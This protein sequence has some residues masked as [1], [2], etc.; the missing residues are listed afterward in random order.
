MKRAFTILAAAAI[1]CGAAE[2]LA[3]ASKTARWTGGGDR[4][5]V[6]DPANWAVT[7]SLGVAVENAVPDGE[8]AVVIEGDTDFNC[9]LG[10]T[11]AYESI[12]I[13]DATLTADCDWRG[14]AL[15]ASPDYIDAPNGAYLDTGFKPNQNTRVVMDVTV[16]GTGYQGVQYWFGCWN[17]AYNNG[18]FA[19]CNDPT[20][21]YSGYGN[22]GGASTPQ[23]ASGRH[24]I[25]FDKGVVKVD[26]VAHTTRTSSDFQVNYNLY[27]FTQNRA[28]TT[29][30]NASLQTVRFHSCQI[31]DDGTLVRDYVPTNNGTAF[32]IYDKVNETFLTSSNSSVPF[33][34]V[35]TSVEIGGTVDLAGHTLTLADAAGSGTVTDLSE[36]TGYI[37]VP[38][39][40]YLDTGFKPNQDTRVVMDVTVLGTKAAYWFGCWNVAFNNGAFAVGNDSGNV[41]SGYG[42]NGGGNG[43]KVSTGR[44]TIDFD[45][46]VVKVD[47]T[48]H[49]TRTAND[50]QVNYNLYLF[51]QNR[52]GTALVNNDYLETIR[53]HS[54]RIYDDG[55]LVRDYVPAYTGAEYG[56]FDKV[57]G[58]F[59]SLGGSA[60]DDISGSV[61]T[62]E[63]HIDVCD[64]RS[65]DNTTLSLS[66]LLKL[67]KEGSG[68]FTATKT[69]QTYVGGTAVSGGWLECAGAATS[70]GLAESLVTVADGAGFEWTGPLSATSSPYSFDIVGT[71]PGG[72]G[73]LVFSNTAGPWQSY[74]L[75]DLS[76]SGDALIVD[77]HTA[78]QGIFAGFVAGDS[79][80]LSLN[81]HT[82]TID[83]GGLFNFCHLTAANA[84]TIKFM[85]TKTDTGNYRHA[86]FWNGPIDLSLVTFDMGTGCRLNID[87]SSG[88]VTF[89]TFIDRGLTEGNGNR[90]LYVRDAFKPLTESLHKSIILGDST[91]LTPVLDLS[92]LDGTFALPASTYTLSAASEATVCV[93]VGERKLKNSEPLVSWTKPPSSMSFRWADGITGK[94]TLTVKDDG[95][96]AIQKG[97][98][99]I[100][101]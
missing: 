80:T 75:K 9:P 79:H 93:D 5:N 90:G 60:T 73:A 25:D 56:I 1:I 43:P 33:T 86:S 16:L 95:L 7:N 63:L 35:T 42:N 20:S 71:G 37:D 82:L 96:Y 53:F 98:I 40:R 6:N 81:S 52:A 3:D 26:D 72:E 89:G 28:G 44:H 34:G 59:L 41:Y 4:T 18:A 68:T 87:S 31:Y 8:T 99:V 13:G 94:G 30:T 47:G 92:G 55:T 91:N 48:V 83:A 45:N 24:T 101:R 19:V 27:L 46:G 76:L 62:G 21:L 2:A 29:H 32:G 85:T 67:V 77:A 64:G 84:G 51:T 38:H 50:F 11:L 78:S 66:G 54:C 65:V 58:E 61:A 39:G 70:C 17:A 12:T 10:Q 36:D 57:G 100:I 69:G 88:N 97:C 14:L 15:S 22:D 23:I 74:C 49:T